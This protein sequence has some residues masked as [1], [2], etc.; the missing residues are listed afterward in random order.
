MYSVTSGLTSSPRSHPSEPAVRSLAARGLLNTTAWLRRLP[1][2][3]PQSF[4]RSR[5][6]LRHLSFWIQRFK[7]LLSCGRGNPLPSVSPAESTGRSPDGV[8]VVGMTQEGF[9]RKKRNDRAVS[10]HT[11]DVEFVTVRIAEI[12]SIE[13]AAT[14]WTSFPLVL[15]TEFD[16]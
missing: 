7:D 2:K 15:C 8:G 13:S 9:A 5:H 12:A 10:A 14:T 6:T 11:E 4:P 1:P 16:G 3:I